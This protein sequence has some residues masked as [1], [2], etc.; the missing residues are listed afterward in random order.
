MQLAKLGTWNTFGLNDALTVEG[1]WRIYGPEK[2][3]C[4]GVLSDEDNGLILKV[5]EPT[6]LTIA[7]LLGRKM[8]KT[9]PPVR[10][11]IY[12]TDGLGRPTT[13]FGSFGRQD[14]ANS[15][16]HHKISALAGV[17][18]FQVQS[19]QE[20][21]VHRVRLQ[22]LQYL[23]RW[24][25]YPALKAVQAEDGRQAWTLSKTTDLECPIS[26]GITVRFSHHTQSSQSQDEYTFSPHSSVYLTFEKPTSLEAIT[27]RWVPWILRLFSLLIG[28]SIKCPSIEVLADKERPKDAIV[29]EHWGRVLGRKGIQRTHMSDPIGPDMLVPF[30]HIKDNLANLLKRWGEITDRLGPI[31][32]LFSTV[33]FNQ[34]LYAQARFLFLAQA[35]EGYH[36]HSSQFDS[37]QIPTEKHHRRVEQ[38]VA[39]APHTLQTWARKKL[40]S[41][42]Y[43]DLRKKLFE[44]FRAHKGEAMALFGQIKKA[45]DRISYTRNYFT[46]Y[47]SNRTSHKFLRLEDM[48]RVSHAAELFLWLLLLKELKISGRPIQLL[49]ARGEGAIFV[50]MKGVV[51][52]SRIKRGPRKRTSGNPTVN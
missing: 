16:I 35:L 15:V 37:K 29:P 20:P 44:V 33:A 23:H 11:V 2:R 13:L 4:R 41:A 10:H 42:N 38:I 31:V 48:V 28:T 8:S 18:G 5:D 6:S 40:E 34:S 32:D 25:G 3:S 36:T 50:N 14:F 17:T 24:F 7:D 43:K 47:T 52:A 46:H 19:W 21:F 26:D 27:E 45:A 39:A 22:Q 51:K 49:I 12:G 9:L 30:A 1:T